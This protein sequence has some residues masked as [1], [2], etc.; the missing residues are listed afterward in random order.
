M[1]LNRQE[2]QIHYSKI[3]LIVFGIFA[4]ALLLVML[5]SLPIVAALASCM[6]LTL[7]SVCVIRDIVSS[8]NFHIQ[9]I[10]ASLWRIVFQDD[11]E[12]LIMKTKVFRSRWFLS[13]CGYNLSTGK[14]FKLLLLRD[15]VHCHEYDQLL[16]VL[17]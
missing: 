7:Y 1:T 11:H 2:V 17:F 12:W 15:S 4:V 5:L 13:L 8:D 16:Y 3:H 6:L 14:K 9:F 10:S